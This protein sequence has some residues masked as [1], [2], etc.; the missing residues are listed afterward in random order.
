MFGH[1]KAVMGSLCSPDLNLSQNLLSHSDSK[2]LP[3]RNILYI[4][5]D[6]TI[7]LLACFEVDPILGVCVCVFEVSMEIKGN[8]RTSPGVCLPMP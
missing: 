7:T 3:K 1:I 8:E 5:T 4:V 2:A 6:E